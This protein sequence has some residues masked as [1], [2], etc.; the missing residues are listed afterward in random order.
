MAKT[1]AEATTPTAP[2]IERYLQALDQYFS[3]APYK[4]WFTPSFEPILNGLGVS[5]YPPAAG[6]LHTDICSQ[7][8]TNPTWSGLG[9]RRLSLSAAGGAVWRDLI[10][11][12]R[13]DILLM[14]VARAHLAALG[15]APTKEWE[16]VFIV[17]RENPYI[18]RARRVRIGD[19]EPLVVF[20]QA[21][22]TPFGT[23]S[24]NDKRR[25]GETLLG[26]F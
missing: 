22:N 26:R 3:A 5:Y 7:L 1:L 2:D 20:G 21:A 17:E 15:A 14:S 8:A 12:L 10:S 16:S 19:A 18:V 4:R 6:A 23:I 24:G 9:A 25:L 13:P 11:A